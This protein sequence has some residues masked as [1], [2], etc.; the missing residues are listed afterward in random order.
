MRR[1]GWAWEC[2]LPGEVEG[3]EV[4]LCPGAWG[5]LCL[6]TAPFLG[7]SSCGHCAQSALACGPHLPLLCLV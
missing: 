3:E 5:G 2:P 4:Q 1:R 6:W 7:L